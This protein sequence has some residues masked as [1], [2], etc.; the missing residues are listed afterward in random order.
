MIR[1][2]SVVVIGLSIIDMIRFSS[3]VGI[4]LS[5]VV[6]IRFSDIVVIRLSTIVMIRLASSIVM[7]RLSSVVMIGFSIIGMINLSRIRLSRIIVYGTQTNQRP[8]VWSLVGLGLCQLGK[9]KDQP[10]TSSDQSGPVFCPY[11]VLVISRV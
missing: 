4:R 5:R 3:A 1:F 8:K 11:L 7:I 9:S 2:S 10:K 6:G